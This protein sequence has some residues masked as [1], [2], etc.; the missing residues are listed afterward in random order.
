MVG[1][2]ESA[3]RRSS[4]SGLMC[5]RV[6]AESHTIV[7]GKLCVQRCTPFFTVQERKRSIPPAS[8]AHMTCQ[9]RPW[10]IKSE[11]SLCRPFLDPPKH[12]EDD[13]FEYL[14]VDI[15]NNNRKRVVRLDEKRKAKAMARRG[16]KSDQS[17]IYLSSVTPSPAAAHAIHSYTPPAFTNVPKTR[18]TSRRGCGAQP[19]LGRELPTH[20][21]PTSSAPTG[22]AW[23]PCEELDP[24]WLEGG[25]VVVTGKI[26]SQAP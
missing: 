8:P 3:Y 24:G 22:S 23:M 1:I 2:V 20:E 10:N 9:K 16:E 7:R 17:H 18:D 14:V 26:A 6:S 11:R 21:P 4:H 13:G 19:A 12:V 15:K 25:S 5:R